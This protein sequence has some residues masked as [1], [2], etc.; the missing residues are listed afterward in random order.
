MKRL[1]KFSL[2]LSLFTAFSLMAVAQGTADNW[3][4]WRLD[5]RLKSSDRNED[6][7]LSYGEMLKADANMWTYYK[8][9][10]IFNYVDKDNDSKLSKAELRAFRGLEER[11]LESRD[12][13]EYAELMMDKNEK[14]LADV[15]YLK[16]NPEILVRLM[17]NAY[18]IENNLELAKKVMYDIEWMKLNKDVR[19][20]IIGNSRYLTSNGEHAR[21][22]YEIGIFEETEFITKHISRMN[23]EARSAQKNAAL[24][25]PDSVK[26]SSS[27]KV[28]RKDKR[29]RRGK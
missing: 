7:M 13:E 17:S 28:S 15:D 11:F 27:K 16:K 23:L 20:A 6:G 5:Q 2:L 12:I 19:D 21:E 3:I 14:K 1:Y 9:E 29:K 22:I 4:K 25:N 10:S 26:K 24:N 8:Q 18:W